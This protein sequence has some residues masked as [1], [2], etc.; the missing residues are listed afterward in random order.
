MLYELLFYI[1]SV[2]IGLGVI[3]WAIGIRYIPHNKVGILEKMWSF[4]GSLKEG[5]LIAL[6]KEAGY[7]AEVLRGGL[8]F[9]YSNQRQASQRD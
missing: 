2:F 8:H 3:A 6:D 4:K 5:K 7:Q 9:T 1:I